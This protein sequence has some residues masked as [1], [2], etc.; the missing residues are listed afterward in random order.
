MRI[1]ETN[2]VY[3]RDHVGPYVDLDGEVLSIKKMAFHEDGE[4]VRVT[5]RTKY[6]DVSG[7]SSEG[8]SSRAALDIGMPSTAT[9]YPY[10][11]GLHSPK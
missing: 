5:V 11:Q 7:W 4:P 8:S 2:L 6:G 1:F 9:I 10:G 3:P